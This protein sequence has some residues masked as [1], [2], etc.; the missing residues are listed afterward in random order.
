MPKA[1]WINTFR[2]VH[3]PDKLAAYAEL[4]GPIM[5]AGGGRF[6]ARGMPA[7][8]YELGLMQRTTVIEFP[9]VEAAIATYESAEYQAALAAL[10]DGAE[11][12]IRIIEAATS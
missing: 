7:A 2:A 10:G 6:L 5:L 4:A 8:A 1:Y 9:S 3:D 11:R 12:D